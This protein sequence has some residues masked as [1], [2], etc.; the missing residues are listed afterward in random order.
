MRQ[1]D[2][3][4]DEILSE[5]TPNFNPYMDP[6]CNWAINNMHFFPVDVNTAPMRDLLRIPG[7]GPVSA[8]RI[9][10]ARR[11][12]KLGLDELKRIGVV[13]KRAKYFII[14]KDD[15][16]GPK[17]GKELTVRSLIDPKVFAFG[18]E[19]LSLFDGK[20]ARLASPVG[21]NDAVFSSVED[22]VEETVLCLTSKI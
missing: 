12:S 13:L 8:K 14:T 17:L 2:F 9:I 5:E 3:T 10:T 21:G 11:E 1:Y 15:P 6:K 7:V 22:A 18:M 20:P 19:Q 16:T 4:S